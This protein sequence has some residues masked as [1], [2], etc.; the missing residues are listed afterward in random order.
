M[1]ENVRR[2]RLRQSPLEEHQLWRELLRRHQNGLR[3]CD[4]IQHPHRQYAQN[5]FDLFRAKGMRVKTCSAAHFF[6]NILP[7]NIEAILLARS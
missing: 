5:Y 7:D 3:F 6:F 2:C 4:Q 1:A